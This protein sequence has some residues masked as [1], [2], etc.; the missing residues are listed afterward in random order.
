MQGD[1]IRVVGDTSLIE[2]DDLGVSGAL[3]WFLRTSA[4]A[5]TRDTGVETK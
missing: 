2:R 3:S 1:V 5:R 4:H